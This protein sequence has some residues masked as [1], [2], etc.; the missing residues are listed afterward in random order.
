[1]YKSKVLS[2]YILCISVLNMMSL[3]PYQNLTMVRRRARLQT[4]EEQLSLRQAGRSS[5]ATCW[6][7][8]LLLLLR[9]LLTLNVTHSVHVRSSRGGRRRNGSPD[10][11]VTSILRRSSS[12]SAKLLGTTLKGKNN[13]YTKDACNIK[14][15]LER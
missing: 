1:M 11:K 13:G 10:W 4:P 7:E 9:A 6:S 2:S 14:D 15:E 12:S 3:K 5:L 8:R